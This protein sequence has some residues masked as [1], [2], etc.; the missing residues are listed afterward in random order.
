MGRGRVEYGFI[1]KAVGRQKK[2]SR[3]VICLDYYQWLQLQRRDQGER[4][5]GFGETNE[6]A[7][8]EFQVR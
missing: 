4:Q 5:D 8:A 7:T 3:G 2:F 6:E 1:L